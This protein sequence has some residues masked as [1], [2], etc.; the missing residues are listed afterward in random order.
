MTDALSCDVAIVG[1]G[2]A[3]LAL[4]RSLEKGGLS[5]IAVEV[6]PEA[7]LR[8]PAP[9]GREIAL[10]HRSMR[11]L[12]TLGVWDRIAPKEISDLREARVL[13]GGS[14]FALR[15]EADQG[16]R[17]GVL[18]SNHLI[19]KALFDLVQDQKGLSL[20]CGR[21]VVGCVAGVVSAGR[22]APGRLTLDDGTTIEAGLIV[23]ADSRFSGVRDLL[24][25]GADIVR[26]GR[27]MMVCRMRH[28]QAHGHVATEWFDH[29]QTVALLPVADADERVSSVVLTLPAPQISAL[30]ALP[31]AAFEAEIER[32]LKG[33]LTGLSLIGERHAYPLATTWSRHF[34]GEGFTLIG[35]AAVGM[36]PVTAHGFNL[37]LHSQ[38]A[39]ARTILSAPRGQIGSARRLARYEAEHRRAALPLYQATR[40]LVRLFTDDAPV[41]RLARGAVLRAGQGAGPFRAAVRRMLTA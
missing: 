40:A 31:P 8:D 34:A 21:R 37:G 18:I 4:A 23:A 7:A 10:T 19:R 26:L 16:G 33:R 11:T 27:S 17:L 32:R 9:D 36:H 12:K 22:P 2:P 3:G 39:L 6:Q 35:D 25:V 29:G 38:E 30:V 28:D 13:D 1:A 14:P 41:A 15:F 5:I 20:M 24:G